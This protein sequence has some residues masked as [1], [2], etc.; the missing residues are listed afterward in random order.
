MHQCSLNQRDRK[1]K[2]KKWIGIAK[3]LDHL[4]K[5]AFPRCVNQTS[6]LNYSQTGMKLQ[7]A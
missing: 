2:E 6:G 4:T 5:S 3:L 1:L 7:V